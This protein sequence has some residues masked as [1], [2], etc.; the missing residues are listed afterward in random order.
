MSQQLP[1]RAP[2][3]ILFGR[4]DD[5]VCP[6]GLTVMNIIR[7][8][9]SAGQPVSTKEFSACPLVKCRPPRPKSPLQMCTGFSTRATYSSHA[10]AGRFTGASGSRIHTA[11]HTVARSL[12]RL[13]IKLC[14]C[15]AHGAR[16]SSNLAIC[17]QMKWPQYPGWTRLEILHALRLKS[18]A[19]AAIQQPVVRECTTGH[20]IDREIS[21]YDA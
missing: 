1:K 2:P 11:M 19:V 16:L 9:Y 3:R 6:I 12:L 18:L 7:S 20:L 8:S 15:A 14:G 13:G 5:F 17:P 21:N 4:A 10:E